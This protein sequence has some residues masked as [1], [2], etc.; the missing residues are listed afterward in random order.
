[1]IRAEHLPGDKQSIYLIV[2]AEYLIGMV[3]A[4]TYLII[5]AVKAKLPNCT[6]RT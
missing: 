4:G 6:L 2:R 5:T 1:M 3:K